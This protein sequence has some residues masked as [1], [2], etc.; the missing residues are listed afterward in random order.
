VK[1][2]T[3]NILEVVSIF[4]RCEERDNELP[5]GDNSVFGTFSPNQLELLL[6]ESINQNEPVEFRAT[7]YWALGKRYNNNLIPKFKA[8]LSQEVMSLED[9]A[10]YQILIALDNIGEPAFGSDR[11]G[12]QSLAARQFTRCRLCA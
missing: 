4:E 12:R 8:W 1:F 9:E 3:E 11:D 6:I 7:A 2:C 5:I 10:V